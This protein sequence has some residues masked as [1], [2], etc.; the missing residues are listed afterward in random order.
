MV[1]TTRRE[2]LAGG[3][4]ALTMPWSVRA[5]TARKTPLL[6]VNLGNDGPQAIARYEAWLGRPVDFIQV[7]TGRRGWADYVDSVHF[8]GR[9]YRDTRDIHWSI[10]LFSQ[11]GTL[12]DA[13]A[14]KYDRY[15]RKAIRNALSYSPRGTAPIYL[16][17][18]WEFNYAGQQWFSGGQEATF[19]KAIRRFVGI[20]RAISPRFRFVWC[21]N[22]NVR[23]QNTEL[24]YPGDDV[25][26][27]ISMDFYVWKDYAGKPAEAWDFYLNADGGYGLAWLVRFGAAHQKPIA[28]DEWGTKF[29]GFESF[30]AA[31]A[32]FFRD[33]DFFYS[34]Y[35]EQQSAYNA[36]LLYGQYPTTAAEF[37]RQFGRSGG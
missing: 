17:S 20:M 19:V 31:A 22:Y 25:V 9:L 16:R 14:G 29:D 35:W 36:A 2:V 18:G 11:E 13:A 7:H 4:A 32:S 10:P 33:N 5:E 1:E 3:L 8:G 6:G 34:A 26:D 30:I 37:R 23:G 28:V 21:P 15:W 12:T 24:S 27:V